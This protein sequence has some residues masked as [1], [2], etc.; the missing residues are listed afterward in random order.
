M[1]KEMS[2]AEGKLKHMI[3]D[4]TRTLEEM[5]AKHSGRPASSKAELELK[6]QIDKEK[7][8][9][10][11]LQIRHEAENKKEHGSK[12]SGRQE[13]E[14]EYGPDGKPL[15]P[16][17][18]VKAEF[19]QLM[20]DMFGDNAPKVFEDDDDEDH[21]H[22]PK[23]RSKSPWQKILEEEERRH[24][25]E[26]EQHRRET[27]ERR[28]A[29]PRSVSGSPHHPREGVHTRLYYALPYFIQDALEDPAFW[30]PRA[31][32]LVALVCFVG[33][34]ATQ[35]DQ[36]GKGGQHYGHEV[37]RPPSAPQFVGG[38]CAL[39]EEACGLRQRG[40]HAGV[41]NLAATVQ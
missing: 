35:G 32:V 34:R 4:E 14:V 19:R 24:R 10:R 22:V 17:S 36:A 28:M 16:L 39:S 33:L 41:V 18:E 13:E 40:G 29:G 30:V 23:E 2:A 1:D 21:L 9:L 27:L 26:E 38:D 25:E 5:E 20:R 12:R 11:Q 3:E 37:P 6:A 15:R 31:A 8:I 7:D